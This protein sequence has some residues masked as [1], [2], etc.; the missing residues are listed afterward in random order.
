VARSKGIAGSAVLV[1]TI[2]LYLVYVGVKDVPFFDGLRSL[3]RQDVPTPRQAHSPYIASGALALASAG[4]TGGTTAGAEG[5]KGISQL[6]GNAKAAYP[7]IRTIAP[8]PIYGWGL[9]DNPSDHPLGKALDVMTKDNVR[10]QQIIA[11]FRTR[12]GA[13]Y[14][15]WNRQIA[16]AALDWKIRP[17]TGPNPH[18]D[19]V[20]LSFS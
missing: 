12:P 8:G 11:V 5:D 18:T 3:L 4:V 20:H 6:V 14:W 9:R 15:I 19:H 2:G 10:A 7:V 13:K 1:G 16:S 17:Y